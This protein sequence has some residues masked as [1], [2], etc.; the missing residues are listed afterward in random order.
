MADTGSGHR[1]QPAEF[2]APQSGAGRSKLYWTWQHSLAAGTGVLIISVLIFLFNARAIQFSINAEAPRVDLNGGVHLPLGNGRYLVT[3]GSYDLNLFA[4]G[5]HREHYRIEITSESP[6]TLVYELRPL[7]GRIRALFVMDDNATGMV[8]LNGTDQGPARE[9]LFPDLEAGSYSLKA[10]AYLYAP[11]VFDVQVRGRELTEEVDIALE[12]DWG[13]LTLKVSPADARLR[14]DT[15]AG[16]QPLDISGGTQNIRVEAGVV[17]L[18]IESPGY[19]PWSREIEVVR[20]RKLALDSPVVLDPLDTEVLVETAPGGAAVTLN[21]QYIGQSPVSLAVLPDTEHQLQLYK[22]GYQRQSHNFTVSANEENPALF[23]QLFADLVEV[24]VSLFPERARLFVNGR[25][26]GIGSQTMELSAVKHHI[27]VRAPGFASTSLEFVPVKGSRQLLQVRLLTDEEALWADVP[28][29]YQGALGQEMVLFRDAGKVPM[30][31]SRR[32]TGRRANEARWTADLQRPFYVS[33]TE[34]TNRQYRQFD[35]EH[36]SGHY[37]SLGLDGPRRPAVGMSWQRAALFCNWLSAR[38][39]LQPFYQTE[40]GYV[41]GVNPESTG[42]RLPTEAEWAY[43]ARLTPAGLVQKFIWGNAETPPGAVENF[44]DQRIAGRINF[45]L[46]GIDDGFAVS[47]PVASF[48]PN[49]RGMHDLAGNVMEW[50]HDWYQPVPYKPGAEVVDPLGP[51]DGEYHVI[52]GASWARGYLPQ[53]RLA[54]RDYDSTGR[55]DLGFRIA[56]Y[57][58]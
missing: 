54:Y 3:L 30:G 48:T 34:I 27:E 42:Y 25:D 18:I 43:L 26:R 46:E 44:A 50:M 6:A 24:Q 36:S 58:M 35:A 51:E 5:Y 22:A 17:Q 49:S 55:N 29:R 10:D 40:K 12:P 7:P 53:L 14:V 39:S 41:S 1:I 9:F 2:S 20:G 15:G 19:K 4:P 32:E 47:A 16:I 21:G 11:Q 31:S 33:S 52:R 57:A 37:Q 23:Y 13:Y 56:R 8:R 45:I 38:E 28:A